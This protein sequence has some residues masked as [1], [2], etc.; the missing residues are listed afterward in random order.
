M[1]KSRTMIAA[2]VCCSDE[3]LEMT[4]SAQALY[5]QLNLAADADGAIDGVNR[6]V[7]GAGF[8]PAD[9]DELEVCGYVV[10]APS[11]AVP[12]VR[13]WWANNKKDAHNYR[14]GPHAAEAREFGMDDARTY[15]EPPDSPWIR[16]PDGYQAD[17]SR[18]SVHKRRERKI[19]K[20]K[21]IEE[22]PNE[23]KP[24]EENTREGALKTRASRG[25]PNPQSAP[26]PECGA[27][28]ITC[29]DE[30][31]G[32]LR[33]YCPVHG[34]FKTDREGRYMG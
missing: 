19:N 2:C 20:E 10:R 8:K 24:T 11:T 7:R 21:V 16:H 17:A 32:G 26:C 5:L 27:D 31:T 3:F 22:N 12:F 30:A 14:P 28:C 1:G 34:D 33:A 15:V 4:P 6:V 29:P 23:E 25:E 9:L 18:T 13:H